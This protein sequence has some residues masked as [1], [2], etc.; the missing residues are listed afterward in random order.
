M[1]LDRRRFL[2]V[3][4]ASLSS[5]LLAACNGNPRRAAKLL[6]FAERKNTSV[7]EAL[8]RHDAMNRVSASARLTGNAFPK[9]FVSD[10]VPMWDPAIRGAWRLEVAGAVRTP[11]SLSLDDLLR[12]PSVTQKVDHFCV[13][14]WNAR[15]AWTWCSRE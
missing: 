12:L 10:H 9:Y 15:A 11:I 1:S 8:F 4:A 6:A 13:E 2:S 7:E 14:G 3:S 5:A